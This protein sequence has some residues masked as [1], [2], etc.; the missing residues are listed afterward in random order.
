MYY[1]QIIFL[2][3]CD[4]KA[5]QIIQLKNTFELYINLYPNQNQTFLLIIQPIIL[6]VFL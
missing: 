4:L 3:G 1:V 5:E 2:A 6:S